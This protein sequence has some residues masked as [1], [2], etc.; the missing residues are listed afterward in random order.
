VDIELAKDLNRYKLALHHSD[1]A[2][3]RTKTSH[4]HCTRIEG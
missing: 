2:G 1:T 4:H 3:F